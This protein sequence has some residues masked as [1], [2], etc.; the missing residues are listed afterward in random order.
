MQL[1]RVAFSPEQAFA[2]QEQLKKQNCQFTVGPKVY[3]LP[4]TQV[5]SNEV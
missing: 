4:D 5:K 2:Q 3:T 1:G